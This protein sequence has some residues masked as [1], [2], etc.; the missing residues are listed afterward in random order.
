MGS[1][2]LLVLSRA[3]VEPLIG[4]HE[5][6]PVVEK[7][8]EDLAAARAV[9]YPV[10]RERIDPHG[11][12]FGVKAAYLRSQ[13][14][15]GYKG[16]GFWKDNRAH[17]LEGHQSLILLYDPVTGAP[18][19]VIDGNYLT[20]LRTGAVGAI[21][22]KHLA[23]KGARTV[24]VI[25]CGAQG[26]IQVAALR[27]VRPIGTVRCYSRGAESAA[28][29]AAHCRA[30]GV[31]AVSCSSEQDAVKGADIIV[32]STPSF[33]PVVKDAWV[34]PGV[35]INAIGADTEGK[36]EIDQAI[37]A[38][39][40]VVVDSWSQAARLGECQHGVRDGLLSSPHAELGE[41]VAG[42]KP[43]REREEEVTVFDATGLAIQDVAVAAYVYEAARARQVGTP[44]DMDSAGVR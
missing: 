44:L 39:A 33:A 9:V 12:F 1:H 22:A 16:G 36:H 11:G 23:R 32:T 25:G 35:H 43:G 20:I 37:L 4:L 30:L 18:T 27:Q 15:L 10:I 28:R 34:T 7:A 38:R 41:I 6:I 19:A 29:F 2:T 3:D 5:A 42:Q 21:A 26:R 40:K 14:Y 31:D 17:G 13:G 24:A 8:F